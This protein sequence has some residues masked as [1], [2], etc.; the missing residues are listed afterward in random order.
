MAERGRDK[1]HAVNDD[2]RC[3]ERFLDVGL[4]DPGDV[5][6]LYIVAADLLARIEA[7]LGIIAVGEQKIFGVLVRRV[8]LL[9][10]DRRNVGVPQHGF[11][12][13]LDFLSNGDAGQ[14][15]SADHR[16]EGRKPFHIIHISPAISWLLE[17][18]GWCLPLPL[19]NLT[20]AD[21][22]NRWVGSLHR[23]RSSEN[24][25]RHRW[26]SSTILPSCT[27]TTDSR[28]AK[29]NPRVKGRH[30][31]GRRSLLPFS[32]IRPHHVAIVARWHGNRIR[33]AAYKMRLRVKLHVAARKTPQP[34]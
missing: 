23:N 21:G 32:A 17:Y 8:E 15:A 14:Q 24:D 3:L 2:R 33:G 18:H 22:D 26:A 34:V 1:H 10:G 4:E 30:Q 12:L 20:A 16:G 5:Q 11:L 25:G 7:R 6:V 31:R 13:L 19:Q 27:K 9:L 29:C 28:Y